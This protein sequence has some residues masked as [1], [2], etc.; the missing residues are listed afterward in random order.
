MSGIK[1]LSPP[2]ENFS[3]GN[4]CCCFPTLF[5]CCIFALL[6]RGCL[7]GATFLSLTVSPH[8][9]D[10]VVWY[11]DQARTGHGFVP[12]EVLSRPYFYLSVPDSGGLS[13]PPNGFYCLRI[14]LFFPVEK[15]KACSAV[16]ENT[17]LFGH[18]LMYFRC[19]M[20]LTE[21]SNKMLRRK[22]W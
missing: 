2:Q 3:G 8:L 13:S 17:Q 6:L 4:N 5:Y 14:H 16:R 10:I 1:S 21:C 19:W 7:S 9:C 18:L 15:A 22:S 12:K 20:Y 11:C